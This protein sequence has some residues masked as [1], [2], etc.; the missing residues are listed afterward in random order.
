MGNSLS[1]WLAL[2]EAAD[3]AA[4]SKLLLDRVRDVLAPMDTV[5]A[6]DLCTG[7]GSNLR[8]LMDRLPQP[9]RWLAIDGDG[10]LLE[11]LPEKLA[12]WAHARGCSVH[13][14]GPASHV[15]CDRF[16]SVI[17]TRQMNLERLD[18]AIFEGRQ[19]VSA[20]ALLDLVSESWL[21]VLA[22]RC[23][24]AGAVAFFTLTYNGGSSCDPAE[25]EDEMVRELM[26]LHQR[27]DKG[28]GGPAAGPDAAALA[29]RVFDDA[30]FDVQRAASDW[31]LAPPDRAFQRMLIE[32]WAHA[33]TEM[34]PRHAEAVA[35]W[36]RRRLEHVEAGRSSVI[37]NHD[38]L[39]AVQRPAR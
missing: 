11:E 5:H 24:A 16:D 13:T 8:Y 3:W 29:E 20:S 35:G 36:L 12:P 6:L 7:T 10:A 39:V 4:R 37:V 32:G 9:Q 21:R 2:R 17:E 22:T 27:I 34:S 23:H 30:G 25:P 33:A 1:E 28:L 26:N 15:R 14:D 19:L 38:D 18:A 31:S